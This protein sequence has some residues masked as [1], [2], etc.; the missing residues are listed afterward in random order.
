MIHRHQVT[1][2]LLQ[3]TLRRAGLAADVRPSVPN[4][5]DVFVSATRGRDP[6][7]EQAA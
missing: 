1:E 2:A 7:Q 5:E 4:L 6:A 3:H